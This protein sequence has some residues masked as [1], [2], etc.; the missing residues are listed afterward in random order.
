MQAPPPA[1]D[2]RDRRAADR[3]IREP[4]YG[5]DRR[6]SGPRAELRFLA[7]RATA[8]LVSQ[9]AE[10]NLNLTDAATPW[11]TT[12]YCDTADHVLYR[13]AEAGGG[14]LLRLRE[15]HVRRPESA[16]TSQRIWIEWKDEERD[17]SQKQRVI[18]R[19]SDVGP[20][21]RGEPLETGDLLVALR[22]RSF[23]ERGPRPVV[24]TQCRRVAYATR[25]DEVRITLDHDLT[26]YVPE[27]SSDG[28]PAPC[29]LGPIVA[30]ETGVLIEL[31][32]QT[33]VPDWTA[34]L[35]RTLRQEASD[36]PSK[37]VVAMRHLA[38]NPALLSGG[39]AS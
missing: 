17:R 7:T 10:T 11:Y 13:E 14:S 25:R 15:Y 33:D 3:R 1:F 22:S 26:Y 30:R 16:L 20:F 23:F 8:A 38:A 18:I 19:P 6:G 9:I 39:R 32:W 29:E 37:F 27:T 31:K 36:R 21:L 5:V 28:E 34:M 4:E 35:L 12:T 24:I 2:P